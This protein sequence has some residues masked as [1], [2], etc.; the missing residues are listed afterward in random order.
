MSD[1]REMGY[2]VVRS[3]LGPDVEALMRNSA[4]SEAFAG[5]IGQLSVDN[6]FG[7]LWS[8]EGLGRRER[9]LVTLGILIALRATEE[10]HYHFPLAL[11]NGLTREE[12]AEVIY[13][14]SG[15]AGFPAAAT[16]AQIG[17]KIFDG[18]TVG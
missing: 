16:A 4:A 6:V 8:R 13:H 11:K 2:E 10:M 15:Y 1:S 17:Q 9:S 5:E 7:T 18:K 3:M 12:L 14:A